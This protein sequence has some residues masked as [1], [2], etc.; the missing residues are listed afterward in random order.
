MEFTYVNALVLMLAWGGYGALHSLLAAE[1]CKRLVQRRWPRVQRAYRIAYNLLALALLIPPF[2]LLLAWRSSPS[3]SW[4]WPGPLGWLADGLAL[5]AIAGFVYTSRG[6]D[7]AEFLGLRQWRGGAQARELPP[8][9]VT[10]P[11]RFVRHPWYFLGLVI[12]W[13]RHMD[14]ALFSTAVA[15]SAYLWIGSLLEEKKL[16]TLYGTAYARYRERVPGLL[17]LPGR[18]LSRGEAERWLEEHKT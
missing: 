18:S 1:S 13:T 2:W 10:G 6:Y 8:L 3:W 9:Q 15:L 17:P 14:P 12:L 16:L 5:A 4:S 7:S 11:H